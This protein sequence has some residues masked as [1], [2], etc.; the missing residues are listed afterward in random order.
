MDKML[1]KRLICDGNGEEHT[2]IFYI[3]LSRH[4]CVILQKIYYL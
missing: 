4:I 1:Q 2:C 3:W